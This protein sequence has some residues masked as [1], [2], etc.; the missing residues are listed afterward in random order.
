MLEDILGLEQLTRDVVGK[1]NKTMN[2]PQVVVMSF[3]QKGHTTRILQSGQAKCFS[4]T[5]IQRLSSETR[6][7]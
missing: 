3:T 1:P 2:K 7:A 6:E 5:D 4:I